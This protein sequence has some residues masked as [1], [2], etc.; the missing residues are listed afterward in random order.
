MPAPS[1]AMLTL[2][3]L[4]QIILFI[5]YPDVIGMITAPG[6]VKNLVRRDVVF[7]GPHYFFT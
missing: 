5:W 2:F 3:S 1:E 6:R 7:S 4:R